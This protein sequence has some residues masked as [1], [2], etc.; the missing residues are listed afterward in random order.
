MVILHSPSL[1]SVK[2]KLSELMVILRIPTGC[3][4]SWAGFVDVN[5]IYIYINMYKYI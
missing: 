5:D 2:S 1:E 3:T 4:S